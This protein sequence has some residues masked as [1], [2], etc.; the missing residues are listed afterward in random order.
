MVDGENVWCSIIS[1][2]H[3]PESRCIY[4]AIDNDHNW[5]CLPEDERLQFGVVLGSRDGILKRIDDFVR[6][7]GTCEEEGFEI[8]KEDDG[9][10]SYQELKLGRSY[11]YSLASF[12]YAHSDD[13]VYSPYVGIFFDAVRDIEPYFY[14]AHRRPR[15]YCSELMMTAAEMFNVIVKR[16]RDAYRGKEFKRK[17][18]SRAT[19]AKRNFESNCAFALSLIESY[20]KVLVL[21]IDLYYTKEVMKG[22]TAG[23]A[24]QDRQHLFNNM[25]NNRLFDNLIG[26]IW[27]L[28]YGER[29]GHHFHLMF[30]FNGQERR[31]GDWLADQI[32][33]YWSEKIVSGSGSYH[34]CNRDKRKYWNCGIGMVHYSDSKMIHDLVTA[35]SYLTKKDQYVMAKR[36]EKCCTIGRSEMKPINKKNVGRPR[37]KVFNISDFLLLR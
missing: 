26:A 36:S 28:E 3:E 6:A 32:G 31:N 21:R 9:T 37:K 22:V 10:V 1:Q 12:I 19:N 27:K 7:V 30:F 33:K 14:D 24:S 29:R 35:I 8:K 11:F 5:D 17:L 25:R 18:R 34:N 13:L 2:S 4:E 16:I 23:M 15:F 20:S